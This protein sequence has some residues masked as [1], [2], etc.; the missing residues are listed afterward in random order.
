MTR[1]IAF[2]Q[3]RVSSSR[4]PGKVLEPLQGVPMIIYMAQRA[5]RAR[6]LDEVIVI[7]STDDSDNELAIAVRS[8]GMKIFRGDLND[9]LR[10]YA[11]A[12]YEYEADEIVRLTGDCP[13]IDPTVIDQTIDTRRAA[14]ADYASNTDPPTFPDG[15]DV[16]CFTRATLD[17]AQ[18][19]ARHP[20]E[21]EHVTVWMRSAEARLKKV[22]HA[23]P[24]DMSN[25]RLTVD[26]PDD[27]E[28]VRSLLKSLPATGDFD[29]YDI[30][31]VLST[32]PELLHA[33]PHAR[34]EGLTRSLRDCSDQKPDILS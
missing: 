8:A 22:N 30:L 20:A 23:A 7:T 32:H 11:D 10:R 5:M 16:E 17:K 13:L 31:R 14:Q 12:A 9:V 3:A 25:L 27:L 19:Y 21:R 34:N 1:T 2:I 29:L 18:K 33:N 4:L 6:R 24:I 15:M 28:L 26:Y